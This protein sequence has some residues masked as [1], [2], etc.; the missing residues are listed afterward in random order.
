MGPTQTDRAL[1]D[2]NLAVRLGHR[3]TC[4]F[5]ALQMVSSGNVTKAILPARLQRRSDLQSAA[6]GDPEIASSLDD[7]DNPICV[8][9]SLALG[10][11]LMFDHTMRCRAGEK[12]YGDYC[13]VQ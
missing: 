3:C 13:D 5:D 2:P 12:N 10:N 4:V 9:L 7:T 6:G 1:D 8:T 11:Y